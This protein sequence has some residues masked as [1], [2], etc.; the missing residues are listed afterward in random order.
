M[1]HVE[2]GENA[3][4]VENG[5]DEKTPP[6]SSA[7]PYHAISEDKTRAAETSSEENSELDIDLEARGEEQGYILDVDVLKELSPR[8]NDYQ[9]AADGRTVLIP[10]P[11][12]DPDDPLN[13]SWTRKHI[14]LLVIAA[15]SFLPDYG[16][17]TGAVTLIP[18]AKEWNMSENH[19]NHSQ[20]GNVFMVGAGGVFVVMLSAYFGRLP[21][22]FYFTATALWT[23]IG[24]AE[25]TNFDTFMAFRILNGFF[26]TVAQGG[27]MMFIKDMFFVHER[28][29][30]I[31]IWASFVILSPY[32]G[33]MIAAFIITTQ[34][35]Q[36]PFHIYTI[37]TTLC[38]LLIILFGQETYYNR[39]LPPHS[40]PHRTPGIRGHVS[41]LLGLSQ[42]RTRHLRNTFP[43]ACSRAFIVLLKPTIFLSVIYYLFTFAW[44]V[45]INTTLSIFVTPLYNFG[46][47]QIGFFY[48]TP[49]VSATVGELFGR[50][51]H[52]CLAKFLTSRSKSQT[53][54]P[55]F[56]LSAIWLST[57][58]MVSGI[59]ILG[60]ALEN[61]WHYMLAALGWGFYVFGIMVTTVALTAYCLDCYPEGSGEVAAW[62]N[63][64][65]TTG[66]FIVSYF[67]VDWAN[68]MGTKKSLGI[69]AGICGA[70]FFVVLFLQVFGERIRRASGPLRFRTD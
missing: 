44:V 14:V 25:A 59:V 31:N 13:W 48:F 62:I 6:V 64:A 61:H 33:P 18:Q 65:R 32:F 53:L 23:A 30:K 4:N 5:H 21:I 28:A 36:W 16:S 34:K 40:R 22:L 55:E 42:F 43:Q 67:Q 51:L 10:Q 35:W 1:A 68:A 60:F 46:P 66:G 11:S 69:Q 56:R 29:R 54:V 52:D 27:G 2:R 24:C 3:Q 70:A 47:K 49:V 38:L 58:F 9:L 19:V 57:P 39:K 45:G 41:R 15:T 12:Q 26:S 17:A 20:S 37:M 63:F 7:G 8:W 50:Y